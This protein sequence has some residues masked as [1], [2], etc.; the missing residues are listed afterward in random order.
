MQALLALN[1]VTPKLTEPEE[2]HRK[3]M[4]QVIDQH[5]I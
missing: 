1:S 5:Y 2:Q 3:E 4:D